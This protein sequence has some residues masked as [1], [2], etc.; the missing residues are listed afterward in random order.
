MDLTT[1]RKALKRG[2]AVPCANNRLLGL[3]YLARFI[4]LPGFA[5]LCGQL[6]E[7]AIFA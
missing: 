1:G 6:G 2:R 4:P 3:I 5:R 7:S